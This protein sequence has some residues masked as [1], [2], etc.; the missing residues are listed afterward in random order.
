MGI[1]E[2][3]IAPH[4]LWKK[5]FCQRPGKSIRR[6]CLDHMMIFDEDHLRRT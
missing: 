3:P 6:K 4:S 1:E 5:P 2:L